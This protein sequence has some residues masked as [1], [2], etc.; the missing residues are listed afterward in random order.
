M[1][2][3]FGDSANFDRIRK[4]PPHLQ[5]SEVRHASFLRVDEEGTEAAAATGVGI[6]ATA[7]RIEPQP[8]HM[9]VD[10]PFFLDGQVL[11]TGMICKPA[12]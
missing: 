1:G 4:P 8:F 7:A 2:I 6:R 12:S 5:I 3:A 10:H 9:V 11:F